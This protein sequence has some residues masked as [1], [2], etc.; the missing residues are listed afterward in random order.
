MIQLVAILGLSILVAGCGLFP[1]PTTPSAPV[2]C[3]CPTTPEV[4]VLPPE[5]KEEV[6]KF[7]APV[8]KQKVKKPDSIKPTEA[9]T[10]T[11]VRNAVSKYGKEAVTL[12]ASVNHQLSAKRIEQ[13]YNQCGIK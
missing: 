12:E 11:N 8:V 3:S 10:C 6:K 4:V 7:K 9:Y 1:R 5:E 2:E 13:I